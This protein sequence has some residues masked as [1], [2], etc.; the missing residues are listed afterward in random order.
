LGR[1]AAASPALR[2]EFKFSIL[3]PAGDF[4][5]GTAEGEQVLLQGVVDCCFEDGDSMTVV[6][7]KSDR[8]KRGEES[9]AAEQYRSQV[10]VYAR[11][12]EQIFHLPIRRRVVWFLRTG[13]GIEIQ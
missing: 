11:A 8:V 6:D 2:R 10:E 1:A 5:P 3:S 13:T 9:A 4:Y 12:L 7:F